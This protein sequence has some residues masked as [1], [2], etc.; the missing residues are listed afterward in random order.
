MWCIRLRT[1]CSLIA[2]NTK[3]EAAIF[4]FGKMKAEKVELDDDY[5]SSHNNP[6]MG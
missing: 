3:K 2:T 4:A 5:R 6:F 1:G